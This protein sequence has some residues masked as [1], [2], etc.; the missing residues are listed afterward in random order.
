MEDPPVPSAPHA[1]SR[2]TSQQ[3]PCSSYAPT[4]LT[5]EPAVSRHLVSREHAQDSIARFR[6][7]AAPG[8]AHAQS[9]ER[10]AFEA[11]LAQPGAT[12][13]RIYHGKYADGRDT[14]VLY[15]YD[16][17]GRDLVGMPMNNLRDWPPYCPETET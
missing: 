13:I 12:G 7:S 15:A 8:A 10:S 4:T 6:A 16:K 11:L 3:G 2:L 17:D 1:H 5:P 9:M 14:L